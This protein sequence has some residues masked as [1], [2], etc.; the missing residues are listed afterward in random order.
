MSIRVGLL[1]FMLNAF[2]IHRSFTQVPL[3][4]QVENTGS[5]CTAPPLPAFNQLPSYAMLPDPFGWSNGSGRISSFSDWACR[6]NEIKAEIENYEILQPV[7]LPE[8]LP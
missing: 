4:Y 3:V 7:T 8:H 6:R 5:N 1:L 2:V